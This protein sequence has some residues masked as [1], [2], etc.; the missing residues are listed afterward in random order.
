METP[1]AIVIAAIIIAVGILAASGIYE[2]SSTRD[3]IANRY[4]KIT[5]GISFCVAG[6]GC[7]SFSEK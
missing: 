4:N 6:R 1:K 7:E 5:G 2:F 3:G